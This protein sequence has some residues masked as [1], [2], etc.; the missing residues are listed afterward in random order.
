MKRFA[1]LFLLLS[2]LTLQARAV[3]I[4]DI[5]VSGNDQT[6][7]A[8]ILHYFY[9]NEAG[10]DW[11]TNSLHSALGRFGERLER[12]GWFRDVDVKE[13]LSNSQASVHVTLKEKIPYSLTAGN[14][15]VGLSKYNLW[16]KG[17]VVRFEIGPIRQKI[18]L[19]DRMFQFSRFSYSIALGKEEHYY[20]TLATNTVT[21]NLL[22]RKTVQASV[23]VTLFPD[24]DLTLVNNNIWLDQTNNT[25]VDS[26]YRIGL[27]LDFDKRA[28]YPSVEKG[29]YLSCQGHYLIPQNAFQGEIT[30]QFYLPLFRDLIF[31]AKAHLGVL[32]APLPEYFQFNLRDIDGLRTLTA[33]PGLIGND[34]WDAHAEAR[35]A[36]WDVIPFFIFDMRLEAL[37]FLDAGEARP[38][39]ADF[40]SPHF[41]AGAGLRVYIDTLAVRV[42]AGVD[43]T[44]E[45]S[46]L[47]GF[48]L[49]F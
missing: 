42:E 3:T 34:C 10:R 19:E 12:T 21:Q 40:G 20:Y 6:D 25:K 29:F 23:G 43:E 38:S 41:V 46:I 49:P 17:K 4:K 48:N 22:L 44:G 1:V 26:Q 37:A 27:K 47:T 14:L 24:L 45:T 15:Y 28:G 9:E 32:T 30:A 35:W 13:T 39:F 18:M 7:S 2:T 33:L 8:T 11:D 31:A 36:F 5:T 16:G